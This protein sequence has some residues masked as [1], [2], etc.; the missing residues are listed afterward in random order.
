M[1]DQILNGPNLKE[2]FYFMKFIVPS[3]RYSND[4]LY[5]SV[6]DYINYQNGV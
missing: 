2:I 3:M 1:S 6:V 4:L 5:N